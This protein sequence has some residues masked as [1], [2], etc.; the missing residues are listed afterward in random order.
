MSEMVRPRSDVPS[1]SMRYRLG[2][3]LHASSDT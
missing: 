1:Q 3:W 2:F